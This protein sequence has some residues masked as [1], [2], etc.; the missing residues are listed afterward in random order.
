MSAEQDDPANNQRRT[1]LDRFLSLATEVRAGEG[2]TA[3]LLAI[4]VF[5]LLS[6][7][8]VIK[9]VREAF[10]LSSGGAEIKSYAAV[11]QTAILAIV[12]PLY[13]WLV[14]KLSR[15][16]LIFFVTFFFQA[17]F[18]AFYFAA[19][20]DLKFVGIA[21]FLFVGVFNVM[22]VAQFWSFANDIY[23]QR[24]GERLFPIVAFGASVGAAAGS[25]T[26][27]LL[28]RGL[29]VEFMLLVATG[30]LG[31][32]LI[33]TRMVERR[34]SERLSSDD[35]SEEGAS[36]EQ[37][38]EMDSPSPDDKSEEGVSGTPPSEDTSGAFKLVLR[39]RYLLM[40]A[41]AMFLANLV[42]TTGEF[43]LSRVVVDWAED[44]ISRGA[45]GGADKDTLIGEF[46]GEFF[47]TVNIATMLLQFFLVSRIIKWIGIRTAVVLLPLLACGSYVVLALFP[48]LKVVRWA[49]V[50]ENS[51]DYSLNN[52]VRNALFL[53][54]S[55]EEK[56][57]AKQATDT[58]FVRGGD[59]AS[60]GVVA[61]GLHVFFWDTPHFAW[62]NV[63]AVG[64][65]IVLTIFIGKKYASLSGDGGSQK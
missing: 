23:T 55:H 17:T 29:G 7:Y 42:N 61:L 16:K 15:Q 64:F 58:F 10:I 38:R 36:E 47:T 39:S 33:L 43:I 62:F 31:A 8:Y 25:A 57:K 6:A 59:A 65:W 19:V 3:L 24:E 20:A 2:F 1:P 51:T 12:V 35:S 13:G 28:V 41:A 52:T 40:I 32:S 48:I 30:L 34:E 63:V 11:G 18:V 5:L 37:R 27:A 46:Y 9:P 22:L 53:P 4:N 49:K 14:S 45:A 21:F 26:T 60:A 50:A 54:L 44:L 56:F